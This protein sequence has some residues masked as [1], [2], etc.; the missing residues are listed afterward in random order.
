MWPEP[1]FCEVGFLYFFL[2]FVCLW[3]SGLHACKGGILPLKSHLQS[4]LLWLFWKWSLKDYLPGLASNLILPISTS[5]VARIIGM[6]HQHL[7]WNGLFLKMIIPQ[8]FNISSGKQLET[9]H[10]SHVVAHT[11]NPST[12]K[13]K[14]G[15]PW[16]GSQPGLHSE[17]PSQK[18]KSKQTN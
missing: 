16:V 18:A 6:S 7:A 11:C 12:W 8:F 9:H 3:Y 10:R 13:A 14:V 2:I 17:T 1:F 15:S 4:I 5:Q